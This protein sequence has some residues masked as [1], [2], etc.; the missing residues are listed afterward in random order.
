MLNSKVISLIITKMTRFWLKSTILLLF[1]LTFS[2]FAETTLSSPA[3][4]AKTADTPKKVTVKKQ[5]CIAKK[6]LPELEQ[7]LKLA[8]TNSRLNKLEMTR[9]EKYIF[10]R[11]LV[12]SLNPFMDLLEIQPIPLPRKTSSYPRIKFNKGEILYFRFDT[13]TN[14]NTQPFFTTAK[15]LGKSKKF[16]KGIILDLRDCSGFDYNNMRKVFSYCSKS[17]KYITR[18]TDTKSMPIIAICL[19]G[20]KTKGAAEVL[21]QAIAASRNGLTMGKASNGNP[22]EMKGITIKSGFFLMVPQVPDFLNKLP[23][24]PVK[25]STQ[26]TE[27]FQQKY[28]ALRTQGDH[29]KDNSLKTAIDLLT[30]TKYLYKKR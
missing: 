19:I 20:K 18:S 10:L 7:L 4:T 5:Q 25:A 29:G 21:A 14:K 28:S 11:K 1:P 15:E 22:F 26:I 3:S 16:P 9:P 30:V 13:F 2:V 12:K 17:E 24:K 23:A 8:Q 6:L 27:S